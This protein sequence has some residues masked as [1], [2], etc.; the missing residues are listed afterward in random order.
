MFFIAFSVNSAFPDL[1][2]PPTCYKDYIHDVIGR[3]FGPAVTVAHNLLPKG[4]QIIVFAERDQP[5]KNEPDDPEHLLMRDVAHKLNLVF[6]GLNV[7][8]HVR[9]C[10]KEDMELK[11]HIEVAASLMERK[12]ATVQ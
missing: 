5:P 8:V 4:H 11:N 9:E 12:G 7:E 6:L 1:D 2:I 10:T 3:A